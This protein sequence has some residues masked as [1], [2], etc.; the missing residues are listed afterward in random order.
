MSAQPMVHAAHRKIQPMVHAPSNYDARNSNLW[1]THR[2]AE[3]LTWL[4]FPAIW[5]VS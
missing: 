5:K 3:S 4:A 2:N 1:R